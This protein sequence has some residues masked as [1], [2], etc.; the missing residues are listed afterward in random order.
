LVLEPAKELFNILYIFREWSGS[1]GKEKC[2]KDYASDEF[3]LPIKGGLII[4]RGW[5]P[6][7][8]EDDEDE[9]EKPSWIVKY[10]DKSHHGNGN[11][12]DNPAPFSK[13]AINNMASI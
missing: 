11:K 6:E 1:K 5:M 12:E 9:K 2:E 13:E 4:H 7:A 3:S 8:K 10:S